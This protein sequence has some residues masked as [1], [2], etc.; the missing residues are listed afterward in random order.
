MSLNFEVDTY[1]KNRINELITKFNNNKTVYINAYNL[2]YNSIIKSKDNNA[3]KNIKINN[4]V[5]VYNNSIKQMLL[6]YNSNVAKIN[7]F[8]VTQ[9]TIKNKKALLIGINNYE[10]DNKLNGCKNDVLNVKNKL[11]NLGYKSNNINTILDEN[12]T[13]KNILEALTK[14]LTESTA[15]DLLFFQYSGHGSYELDNNTDEFNTNCDQD[16]VSCD[17]QFISDDTLKNVIKKYLKQGVTL[18]AIFD[19]CFSGSVLDL[20]YQYIDSLNKNA[21]IENINESETNGNVI[22]I[23][24]CND[25]QK[26]EDAFINNL[27]QGAMTWAF[28]KE[29]DE[30][31]NKIT[32]RKLVTNMR[33]TLKKNGFSQTPQISSGNIME[34]DSQILI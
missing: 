20:R 31:C 30:S 26:S 2:A 32:W 19:S 10:G 5:L 11:I 16:I 1:K 25:M 9:Y 17:L 23:S 12:A 22:M 34:L 13:G 3:V 28:L 18:I 6:D 15:G 29:L 21:Y 24:G 8:K 7:T 4:L 33:E 14:I 27:N